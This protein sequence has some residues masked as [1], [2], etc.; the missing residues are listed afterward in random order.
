V[1]LLVTPSNAAEAHSFSVP[2]VEETCF[3]VFQL[4]TVIIDDYKYNEFSSC[5]LDWWS[6]F[7]K[8]LIDRGLAD[9]EK[10]EEKG[11]PNASAFEMTIEISSQIDSQDKAAL[12][13]IVVIKVMEA[14]LDEVRVKKNLLP[15]IKRETNS[16]KIL[17]LLRSINGSVTVLKF[18]HSNEDKIQ[19]HIHASDPIDLC[20]IRTLLIEKLSMK[21]SKNIHLVDLVKDGQL[22]LQYSYS[23]LDK[24]EQILMELEEKKKGKIIFESDICHKELVSNTI[25][26]N[27]MEHG[28]LETYYSIRRQL[29]KIIL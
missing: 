1:E 5:G 13:L 22:H 28:I 7:K 18:A 6:I 14:L 24:A 11:Q 10:I 21:S 12:L 2:I 17:L 16:G 29:A 20:I 8:D 9:W 19:L 3:H 15:Q 27:S 25:Q 23:T 26:V 4:S